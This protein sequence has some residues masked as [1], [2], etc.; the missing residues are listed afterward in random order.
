[1]DDDEIDGFLYADTERGL[2]T[3]APLS[4][5]WCM[6]FS[7][8]SWVSQSTLFEIAVSSGLRPERLLS[9]D[10]YP[11]SS[12]DD[13]WA[14]ATDDLMIFST[15][16]TRTGELARRFDDAIRG[17][18]LQKHPLKDVDDANACLCI[19][20]ELSDGH[21]WRAPAERIL[22]SLLG[23][24]DAAT[25]GIAAPRNLAA[26]LGSTQW[27]ALL[28]R[29]LLSVFSAVY[30]D[31]RAEPLGQ[32]RPLGTDTC[33]EMI[34]ASIL[35]PFWS[36]NMKRGHSD[37]VFATDASSDF[38][39]GGVAATLPAAS[40]HKLAC[41]TVR[42]G[43]YAELTDG[44]PVPDSVA[45]LGVPQHVAVRAADFKVLFGF[46]KKHD[47]HINTLEGRA[48]LHLLRWILRAPLRHGRRVINLVDSKVVLGALTK[49]RSSAGPLGRICRQSA[50][51]VLGGNLQL[52]FIYVHT[53]SNP[54]DDPSRNV[55]SHV[56]RKNDRARR[57]PTR[58]RLMTQRDDWS[59]QRKWAAAALRQWGPSAPTV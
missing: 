25:T 42:K 14:L 46:A 28:R 29:E 45:K 2:P 17:A 27:Y 40:L 16:P 7:W 51:L 19:G 15:S 34:A 43:D 39:Y 41:R 23:A 53:H 10:Q 3:L 24:R 5:V 18:N 22:G 56:R 37:H 48:V 50:A 21:T 55:R 8:S 32:P 44:S 59:R 36:I 4:R 13:A 1:M 58:S 52:H 20:V 30:R 49:G 33:D 12:P 47:A 6:G 11:P 26:W 31:A 54:A 38:G 35:S 9:D 57:L